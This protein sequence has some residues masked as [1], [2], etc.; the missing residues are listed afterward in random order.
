MDNEDK[1]RERTHRVNLTNYQD[2]DVDFFLEPD[3]MMFTIP[4]RGEYKVVWNQVEKYPID[5]VFKQDKEGVFYYALGTST[6]Y[7]A[8]YVD[9]ELIYGIEE[10]NPTKFNQGNSPPPEKPTNRVRLTNHQDKDVEFILESDGMGFILSS[11][12][13]FE[14]VWEQQEDYSIDFVFD[15]HDDGILFYA[16]GTSTFFADVYADGKLIFPIW[17]SNKEEK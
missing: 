11:G 14:V 13:V 8:V 16:L 2:K 4:P 5:F 17:D 6:L 9:R 7:A 12:V 15:H 1:S 10:A 3:G